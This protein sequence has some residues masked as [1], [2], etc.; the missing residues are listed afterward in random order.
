MV[1]AQVAH[2]IPVMGMLALATFSDSGLSD[3]GSFL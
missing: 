1:I 2:V 3:N